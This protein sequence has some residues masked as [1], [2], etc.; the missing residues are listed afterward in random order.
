MDEIKYLIPEEYEFYKTEGGF[1]GLKDG[2]KDYGR[3][4]LYRAFPLRYENFYISVRD[5]D[6]KEIG[7]IRDM[8]VFSGEA[9]TNM[10]E[11]LKRRY[12]L[13]YITKVH[14]IKQEFGYYYWNVETDKG[15]KSFMVRKESSNLISLAN[16]RVL[17]VDVDGN[18]YEIK[19][20]T[21]LDKKSFR[22]IELLL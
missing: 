19:D 11:E 5:Q 6:Q 7:I 13:P 9:L 3:V 14:T 20:Y 16:N 10:E 15:A 12:F 17:V 21:Q 22:Q 8:K 2:E 1:L 4:S 18:R